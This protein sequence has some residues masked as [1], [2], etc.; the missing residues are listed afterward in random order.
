MEAVL[1]SFTGVRDWLIEEGR[2]SFQATE[3][4]DSEGFMS[5]LADLGIRVR[6]MQ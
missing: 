4:F 3:D 2:V 6:Q 1:A 5:V